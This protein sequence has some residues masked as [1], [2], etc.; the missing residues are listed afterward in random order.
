MLDL[1]GITQRGFAPRDT[2]PIDEWARTYVKVGAWSPWEGDFT[3]DRTPW[4]VEPLQ[5]LGLHGPRRETI[6]GPAAGSK[7]TIG[8]VFLSWA[9]DNA[10]GFAVWYNQDEEAAKEFAETRVQRFLASC[11]RVSRLF[12][13]NRHQKRTQAIHFPHMS[14]VIQAANLGNVQS[15]HI[16]HMICDETHLWAAGMLAAAHKRTTRFAHNRTIIELSTGSMAGDETDQAWQQGTKQDWQLW[17]P[18]CK[19]LHVPRW[20]RGRKDTPG[21]VKWDKAA[22]RADG[23]WD[24]RRVAEST[25]YECP[26]CAAKHV[27]SAANGYAMNHSGR[28]TAPSPDAMPCHWSF[29]WN[30]IASDFSQLG[31]IAV[32]FLQAMAAVKRG[33]TELLKEFTQKKLAEAWEEKPPEID[34]AQLDSNYSVGEAWEVDAL[35]IMAVDVQQTHF[36]AVIRAFTKDGQ[37]RMV[38]CARL[39]SWGAVAEFAE[40][41]K[42]QYNAVV[43]DSG[44]WPDTVY[45][46]CCLHGWFPIKGEAVPGGYIVRDAAN[47]AYR[48]MARKA[49]AAARPAQLAPGSKFPSRPLLLISDQLSSEVL[50]KARS[51]NLAGW[52]LAKDTP[53]FYR[54]QLAS[55]VRVPE[56]NRVTGQTAWVWK[57]FGKA[58]NHLWDCERYA[59]AAAFLAGRF[60][61]TD[62]ARTAETANKGQPEGGGPAKNI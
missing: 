49:E 3:T 30:C 40:T 51:G 54:E 10:P 26:K 8:E 28:Y 29:H 2:R 15:K 45:T 17:C 34:I 61:F 52:T 32:E 14:F 31:S 37:S 9:I 22:K 47:R 18:A 39:D 36:W 23:T 56:K 53:Q 13:A 43:V 33:T 38:T 59:I 7:S 50:S 6:L 60:H 41:N 16:R 58:G 46:Q 48:V 11:E 35:R 57:E 44:K 12:P 27:P 21:G 24:L 42:V 19:S 25:V 20:S 5:V 55:M 62:I 1:A 4:I